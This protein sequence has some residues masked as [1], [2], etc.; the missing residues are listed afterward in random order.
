MTA[1]SDATIL[2]LRETRELLKGLYEAR[3][4]VYWP[5]MLGSAAIGWGTFAFALR[6]T[7]WSAPHLIATL[8]SALALYRAVMFVHELTH[9]SKGALPFFHTAWDLLVGVPL[10]APSFMYL[11][12]HLDH[13]RRTLY[14]TE[15]DPEYLPL[16]SSPRWHTVLFLLQ[17]LV[18]PL[19]LVAR[20][21]VLTPL[22]LLLGR[23][24]RA[25]LVTRGAA[26]A[27]NPAYRRDPPKEK[28]RLRWLLTE[29]LAAALALTVII[30]MATGRI[31]W[32]L[33]AEWYLVSV[34]AAFINQL[35]TVGAHRWRNRGQELDV[36][37]QLVDSVNT[38]G[39]WF[40]ELWAPV[41][42]RWHG[43][44]HFVPDLPYHSLGTAHRRLA[45]ALPADSPYFRTISRSLWASLSTLWRE[46]GRQ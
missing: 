44:H 10:Q 40:T 34:L 11:G 2:T 7:W 8:I 32:H 28:L 15:G 18:I 16:A 43:L 17:P 41:G 37:E 29:A 31:S 13:H 26:L 45:A 23:R 1:P 46:A 6:Q 19:L 12:V 42:L 38:P 39:H 14:G 5:D 22:S 3:R 21:S 36:V 35:R 24:A 4:A 33:G 30:G 9:L 20:F 25:L 27:I